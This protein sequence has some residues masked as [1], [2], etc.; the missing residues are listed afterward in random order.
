[1]DLLSDDDC[2]EEWGLSYNKDVHVC[3]QDLPNQNKGACSV[4]AVYMFIEGLWC[5]AKI[6]DKEGLYDAVF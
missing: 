4:S 3:V 1:M 2:S 5:L 6:N